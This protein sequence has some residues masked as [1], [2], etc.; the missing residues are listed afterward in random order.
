MRGSQGVKFGWPDV[1]QIDL[2]AHFGNV[3][4]HGT[5]DPHDTK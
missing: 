5:T 3:G 2:E 4:I 1:Q